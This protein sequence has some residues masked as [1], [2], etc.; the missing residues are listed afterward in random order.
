MSEESEREIGKLTPLRAR[1]KGDKLTPE[2]RTEAQAKFIERFAADGNMSEAC[3]AA[4]VSRT[5]VYQWK[6]KSKAFAELF[7]EAEAQ[8]NDVIRAEIFRRAITGWKEPMVSAGQLVCYAE[9]YSDA[10][11]TLLAK[12]R[13]SE[14]RDKQPDTKITVDVEGAKARLMVKL[15]RL[16]D[17]EA[18]SQSS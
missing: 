15:G 12:S 13:M 4:G 9:K 10:M 18:D 8:A 5:I 7:T 14:F 16:P 3:R 6:E 1:G 11:L 17:D 2:E